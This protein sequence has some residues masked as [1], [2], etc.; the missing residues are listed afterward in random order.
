MSKP[1]YVFDHFRRSAYEPERQKLYGHPVEA[2]ADSQEVVF[3]TMCNFILDNEPQHAGS[4][5]VIVCLYARERERRRLADE[6][7]DMLH[8]LKEAG[9][10][11]EG[12]GEYLEIDYDVDNWPAG[13][14]P[15]VGPYFPPLAELIKIL[16]DRFGVMER[17]DT[18]EFG[19]YIPHDIGVSGTGAT[20]FLA[21]ARLWL[22]S[23]ADKAEREA[24]ADHNRPLLTPATGGR[25]A[26]CCFQQCNTPAACEAIG[27]CQYVIP[28]EWAALAEGDKRMGGGFFCEVGDC[29]R[30]DFCSQQGK[31]SPYTEGELRPIEEVAFEERRPQAE[32]L[33]EQL[34]KWDNATVVPLPPTAR[35][36][37]CRL[38]RSCPPF[39]GN[40]CVNAGRCLGHSGGEQS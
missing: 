30:K 15:P 10:P 36:I 33:A 13:Q 1:Q 26:G 35:I 23:E 12:D 37:A 21:V 24:L 2:L 32:R 31:C 40:A 11:Q 22:A 18:G 3:A 5:A 16:G 8:T 17:F 7:F 27:Y 4:A 19:A 9:F 20:P 6:T 29:D 34:N 25:W 14:P 28:E 39:R 38:A